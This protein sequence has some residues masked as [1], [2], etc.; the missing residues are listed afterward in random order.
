MKILRSIFDLVRAK[1]GRATLARKDQIPAD[2]DNPFLIVPAFAVSKSHSFNVEIQEGL[3]T[4]LKN[5]Y[6]K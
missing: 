6:A 5:R 4:A 1:R 3:Q 2:T